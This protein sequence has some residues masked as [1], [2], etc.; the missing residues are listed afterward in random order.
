[1]KSGYADGLFESMRL[2]MDKSEG[3]ESRGA[4]V[5]VNSKASDAKSDTGPIPP[6]A[7]VYIVGEL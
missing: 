3:L 7:S 2:A 1:M 6:H 5:D 4:S